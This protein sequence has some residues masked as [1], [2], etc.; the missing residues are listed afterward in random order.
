M[1]V[2]LTGMCTFF[3]VYCTQPLL[4][5]LQDLFHASELE[6]SLTVSS[7][8]FAIALTAPIIGMLAERIGRK[9]VIV[10]ALFGLTLATL[11]CATA[12]SLHALI[13]WRFVQG[14]FVPGVVA[15]VHA[16]INEEWSG[17]G[18]GR[19]MSFYVT[20]TV[21][22]GFLGRFLAGVI[23]SHWHWR[24]AFIVIGLL[25]LIGAVLVRRWLPRA[26]NFV[27]APH[28]G[29]ALEGVRTHLRN[30]RLL[31]TFG[32]GFAVLFT[33]VGTFTYT[34]FYLA[35]APF[36]LTS[37]QLGS[38]F[39]VYLLGVFITPLSGKYLDLYGFRKTALL[40]FT[41]IASGLLLTLAHTLTPVIIGLAVFSS[42]VFI[43]QAAATVQTG[44][45][46]GHARSS[47]AGLYMSCY[48][49]GGSAGA[50]LTGWTWVAAGWPACIALLV[51]VA[52]VSLVLAII[53]SRGVTP[54]IETTVARCQLPDAS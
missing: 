32:M 24:A 21:I 53:S 33:L 23:V 50:T 4:P 13:V 22:G 19:A 6:V 8:T 51:S 18:V 52:I 3:S 30:P 7:T 25:N 28:L 46:A 35:K 39:F 34:N 10:P 9:K 26:Q 42:G 17:R 36:N 2:M 31:A 44:V 37:A 38:V 41:M 1:A 43:S 29:H 40:S 54:E 16:Y 5:L 49:L 12:G 45:I 48:Y 14:L 11:L 20:G 27:R 47:A 15:V